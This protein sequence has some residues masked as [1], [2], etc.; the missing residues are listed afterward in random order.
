VS[1]NQNRSNAIARAF[2]IYALVPYLGILF[3]PGAVV[4]GTIG[5]A[6]SYR[7]PAVGGRVG[8]Y[9]SIGAG[10]LLLGIQLFLWWLLYKVPKW[11]KGF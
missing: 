3:C 9:L 4:M 8:S 2:A 1:L 11:A 6:Q 5:L 7:I 10:L